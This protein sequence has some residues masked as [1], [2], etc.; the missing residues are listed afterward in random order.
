MRFMTIREEGT[1]MGLVLQLGKLRL[2][3][4]KELDWGH[5]ANESQDWDLPGQASVGT[6]RPWEVGL[7]GREGACPGLQKQWTRRSKDQ[8]YC[9]GWS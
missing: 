2:T 8:M 3:E 4:V 9:V 1:R 7:D 6:S 5:S